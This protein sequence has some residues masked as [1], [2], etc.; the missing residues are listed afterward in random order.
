MLSPNA[1]GC[2]YSS[3]KL[4]ISSRAGFFLNLLLKERQKNSYSCARSQQLPGAWQPSNL[5]EQQINT[6]ILIK[7]ENRLGK[8]KPKRR[9]SSSLKQV[10]KPKARRSD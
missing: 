8:K 9:C 5:E 2:F 10:Y 1:G 4:S 6:F 3:Y 7:E